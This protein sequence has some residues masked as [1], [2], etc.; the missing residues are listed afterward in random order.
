M[1]LSKHIQQ[2]VLLAAGAA[3]LGAGAD[4]YV[5]TLKLPSVG[6]NAPN[7]FYTFS[8]GSLKGRPSR[9]VWLHPE[10]S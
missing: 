7:G 1:R 9:G 6:P 8:A 3:A 5:G 4:N 10:T 2:L